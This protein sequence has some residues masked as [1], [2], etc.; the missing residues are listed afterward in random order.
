M[1][2]VVLRFQMKLQKARIGFDGGQYGD[3]IIES[4][5]PPL[6][7]GLIRAVNLWV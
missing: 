5:M 1:A 3:F 6:L 2:F 7:I 4:I